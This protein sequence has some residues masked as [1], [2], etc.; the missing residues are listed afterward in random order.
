MNKDDLKKFRESFG[1]SQQTISLLFG[2]AQP[3]WNRYEKGSR[4]IPEYVQ[5]SIEFFQ[6]LSKRSQHQFINKTRPDGEQSLEP[7]LKRAGDV[8]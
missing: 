7:D 6:A 2:V 1:M 4:P 5:R 8:L 3:A